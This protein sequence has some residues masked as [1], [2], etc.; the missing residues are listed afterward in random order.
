MTTRSFDPDPSSV[1]SARRFV[2]AELGGVAE[3]TVEVAELLLS[4]LVTNVVRHART[5]FTVDLQVDRGVLRAVVEDGVAIDV[6]VVDLLED[7][8]SG[9][10]LRIVAAL[11]DEWGVTRLAHGKQVWFALALARS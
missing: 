11:A 2:R 8:D 6:A 3:E 4:E 7:A 1:R 10:G 5:N 9:R